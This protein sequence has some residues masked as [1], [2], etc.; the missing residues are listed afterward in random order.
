MEQR[1]LEV[2]RPDGQTNIRLPAFPRR[3]APARGCNEALLDGIPLAKETTTSRGDLGLDKTQIVI[4]SFSSIVT[5]H[6]LI[7][8]SVSTTLN[9]MSVLT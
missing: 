4:G 2:A 7:K 1:A 6:L 5:W 8:H 9:S 3:K